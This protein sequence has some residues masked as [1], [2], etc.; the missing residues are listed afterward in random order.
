MSART[1]SA[2]STS[3]TAA[4]SARALPAG[5]RGLLSRWSRQIPSRTLDPVTSW[6]AV[7]THRHDCFKAIEVGGL[8]SRSPGFA[9]RTRYDG[10][11]FVRYV[12]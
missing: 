4:P 1:S 5:L 8:L 7:L 6:G 2:S 9:G 3:T 10:V 11:V 12:P